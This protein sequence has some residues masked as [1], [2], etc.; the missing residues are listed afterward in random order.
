[1]SSNENGYSTPTA[2]PSPA[3]KVGLSSLAD[4]NGESSSLVESRSSGKRSDRSE[5]PD[6]DRATPQSYTS[7]RDGGRSTG[8]SRGRRTRNSGGFLLDSVFANGSPRNP[9]QAGKQKAN[10]GELRVDR[11]RAAYRPPSG[12][13]SLRG[14]PLSREF[15]MD[16]AAMDDRDERHSARPVS[17]DASNL[18]QMALNLNESR[19]RHVSSTLQVPLPAGQR[20]TSAPMSNYGTVRASSSARKRGSQLSDEPPK[21]SPSSTK[22]GNASL[23]LPGDSV[24][25]QNLVTDDVLYTFSPA[26]LS[27]AEKARKYFELASEHRRLL[28]SLPPLKPDTEAPGNYTFETTSTPGSAYPQITRVASSVSGKHMLGRA[29]NPIQSLRNRR[30]RQR[31]KRPFPAREDTWQDPETV[32]RWIDDVESVVNDPAY[33]GIEDRVQLPRFAGDDVDGT[34]FVPNQHNVTRHRRTDTVGSVI[35]RPENSWTIEPIELLADAYW[36]EQGD[37]KAYIETRHG[38]PI[39]P[40]PARRSVDAPKISIEMHRNRNDDFGGS[41]SGGNVEEAE[42][43]A[44]R[45]KLMLPLTRTERRK[46][47]RL[48]S[49]STSSSSDSSTEG[50]V[51]RTIS[52]AGDE[53]D[54]NIGPLA[55]HMQDLIAKDEKG[56]LSSSDMVSPDHWNLG[57]DRVAA[58]NKNVDNS[59]RDSLSRP[60][61]RASL[62]VPRE[63]HRRSRSADGRVGS[64]DSALLSTED[65]FGSEPVSPVVSRNIP[66][67]G[68]D[69]SPPTHN[70]HSLDEHRPRGPKLPNFRSRSKERHNIGH[71]DFADGSGNNLSQ[72]P[73]ASLFRPRSSL[74]DSRPPEFKRHKTGESISSLRRLDTGSSMGTTGSTRESGSTVGRLLK[75]GRDRIGGLVF[76]DRFK[77]RDK[78][79][80][81]GASDGSGAASDVEDAEDESRPNGGLKQ[82]F[83]DS[84]GTSTDVSPR[85][86]LDR[87]RPKSKYYLSNLPS[88]TPSARDKRFQV[89]SSTS[90]SSD[91]I[92][93]QQ[94]AQKE[95]GQSERFQRLAPPRI[96]MPQGNT[97]NPELVAKSGD[98]FRETPKGYGELDSAFGLRNS[99]M[100][101][102][103]TLPGISQSK[104]HW[105]IYDQA[106]PEQADKVTSRD[107][108]RVKALLLSS[109]I[110]AREIQ[111]RA[112]N[113]REKPLTLL[114]AAETAGQ[115]LPTVATKEEPLVAARLLSTHLSTVLSELEGTLSR[116]QGE[117]TQN[118]GS[119]LDE[120]Q[121]KATE[122]LTKLLHDKSDEADAFTVELTTRQP[123]QLKQVNDAVDTMLRRRRRQFRIFRIAGFKLLEWLVLSIMWGIWFMVVIFNT[124]KR[125]IIGVW[126]F[127]HWL[128]VF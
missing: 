119:Q 16:G 108:A 24:A 123:Q 32:K 55:R 83:T 99:L 50:R 2:T 46:H 85:A 35:T 30:A 75:G 18:V 7:Q 124:C 37:N 98:E 1:M 87:V 84:A 11:R 103:F 3:V 20:V 69:L 86:S 105:S 74:E 122:H 97:S 68:I 111:R 53:G 100:P 94:K 57:H 12:D 113:P 31:G 13:S 39:F 65:G 42:R 61:G 104:R 26:T 15:L 106:Q 22:T 40:R 79:D 78:F 88:F 115:S 47:T 29:Y 101:L 121:H 45:R 34:G 77:N 60:N 120:L 27:R 48:M 76:S 102:G 10:D 73:S 71:A 28:Q 67:M 95:T 14:S 44:R 43:P 36:T 82:R 58:S 23:D 56:E 54:T 8:S 4:R 116:F 110:K 125:V 49:R 118:L 72:I 81:G 96:S 21:D 17:L 64:F 6:V 109:G 5:E 126:R 33:R 25:P 9:N 128:F 38:N 52:T 90:I 19:K 80:S 63:S 127:L 59:H 70:R 112:D 107:I 62:E 41:T 66:S 114:K 92:S 91:P 93:Q 51:G 117:T 89:A